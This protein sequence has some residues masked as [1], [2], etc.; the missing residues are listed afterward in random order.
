VLTFDKRSDDFT[1]TLDAIPRETLCTVGGTAVTIPVE[2]PPAVPLAYLR[3]KMMSGADVAVVWAME[4]LMT[5]EGMN[6]FLTAKLTDDELDT[7]TVEIIKRVSGASTGTPDKDPKAS[8]N[9]ARTSAPRQ[10]TTATRS[11]AARKSG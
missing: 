2:V 7:V 4:L 10:R 1:A 5:T 8:A 11:R 3:T 6:V 9:G